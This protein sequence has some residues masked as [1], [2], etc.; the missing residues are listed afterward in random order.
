MNLCL[1]AVITLQASP[2]VLVT[3][4][5]VTLMVQTALSVLAAVVITSFFAIQ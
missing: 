1:L 5:A 3:V 2:S 4:I